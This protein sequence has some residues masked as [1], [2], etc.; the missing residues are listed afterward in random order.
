MNR[1]ETG[2]GYWAYHLKQLLYL[3]API[4]LDS[5]ASTEWFPA[6]PEGFT[7]QAGQLAQA[8]QVIA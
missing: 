8:A 1:P 4:P 2:Q 6:V 3:I 5:T 7:T